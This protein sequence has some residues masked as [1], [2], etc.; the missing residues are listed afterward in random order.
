MFV[1]AELLDQITPYEKKDFSCLY[2]R[3]YKQCH[4]MGICLPAVLNRII[5]ASYIKVLRRYIM[6]P[7]HLLTVFMLLIAAALCAQPFAQ[8]LFFSEYLE[9]SSN[10]KAIEIFNGTGA[11]VDLSQYTIKLGSNGGAWSTTNIL[12]PTVTL[13][14]NDVFVIVNASANAAIQAVA[15]VQSTVTYFNGDDCL[16]L[17]QGETMI[18]IFG[19]YQTDPGTAWDVA[20]VTGATLNHTLVRKPPVLAGNLNWALQQGTNADDSEWIVYDQDYLTDLGTHVFTPGV[21]NN[22]ATP[23]FNP[24]GGTYTSS[25]SVTIT[26]STPNSSIFYTNDGTLP[27]PSSTPYSE[28]INVSST[29]TLKAIA[30]AA[31]MDNSFVATSVYTFPVAVANIAALRSQAMGSTIYALTGEAVLTFQQSNR[32]QKYIQD[33]TAAI[34]ID[35]PT[36]IIATTYNLGDGITG[37]IG[38]LGAYSNLMQFTPISDPGPASSV[39]NVI[40]PE[41]RTLASLVPADQAKLIKVMDATIDPALVTFPATATNINVTDATTTLVLRTFLNADYSNTAIPT[42][43]VHLICLVGQFSET[44]QVS[45]RFL[46]DFVSTSTV[47]APTFD[48]PQGIYF[49]PVSVVLSCDSAN[50]TINYTTDGSTPSMNSLP[51]TNPIPVITTTTIKAIAYVAGVP[52]DVSTA[53]Y[54]YPSLVTSLALL[55]QSALNAVYRIPSEIVVTFAQ[56]NRHQKFAQDSTA[57]I[58]IDDNSGVITSTY[59][60]GDGMANLTGTLTEFGGMLEFVPVLDPGA[61]NSTGNTIT[62]IPITLQ[63]F[64]DSFENYESRLVKLVD[65][66]FTAPTGNFANGTN[67]GIQDQGAANTANF[68]TTFYDVNYTGVP[69]QT[70]MLNITGIPNSRTDGNY[71]T[72]RNLGDFQISEPLTPLVFAT[73]VQN[74]ST[75]AFHIGFDVI[76]NSVIPDMLTGYNLYRDGTSIHNEGS[77][78]SFDFV[79]TNIPVGSHTYYAIAQYG[80]TNSNP[81]QEYTFIVTS[82]NDNTPG[83]VETAL[84]GNSPNPFNGTTQISFSLKEAAPVRIEIFN[85]KG[86]LIRTLL[87]S[88]QNSGKHE[89]A[90]DGKDNAGNLAGSGIYHYRMTCGKYSSTRKMVMLK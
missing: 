52:S 86:Q 27:T 65:V 67:Y 83:V 24:A 38:T 70:W 39:G 3:S 57:G 28:P 55:R 14:N 4:K 45:P 13:A 15:D 22:V 1:A 44:M 47:S 58:L 21:G 17:F 34:V 2:L 56:N 25:Q 71:I 6:R 85:Q 69:L 42:N 76:N 20:G 23:V 49:A 36:G 50:A 59:Q 18:D 53:I 7:K 72:A 61:P 90:W 41:V 64:N 75:L 40:I 43:P 66:S 11:P 74:A 37:I 32:H 51:Y 33:N 81:T 10:N 5:N 30:T 88:P 19:V 87:N 54:T 60:I 79:D 31:G 80:A 89:L 35:D 77:V 29:V 46:T 9:G 78:L 48:P 16:G 8:T 63:Q 84:L 73:T 82:I 68:R 62:P 26:C 12:T